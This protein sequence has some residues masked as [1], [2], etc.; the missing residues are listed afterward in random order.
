M[1]QWEVFL[2]APWLESN[3]DAARRQ[4]LREL[5]SWIGP[6]DRV[7]FDGV[8]ALRPCDS[9]VCALLERIKGHEPLHELRATEIEEV[10]IERAI[11]INSC[12][13]E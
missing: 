4:V 7:K 12:C 8:K 9:F 3:P 11:I 13:A 2:S 6:E 1:R 5:L 10:K